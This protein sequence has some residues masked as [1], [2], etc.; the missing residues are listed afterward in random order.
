[1]LELQ[2]LHE[3][4][5]ISTSAKEM[6]SHLLT[7]AGVT[8][9]PLPWTSVVEAAADLTWTLDPYDRLIVAH[10]TVQQAPL[11]TSDAVIL[12]NYERALC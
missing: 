2:I 7:T 5:R 12:E 4:R 6:L 9:C 11:V 10:A 8:V 3:K 1:V